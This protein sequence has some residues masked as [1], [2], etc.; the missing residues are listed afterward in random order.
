MIRVIRGWV[1]SRYE[2]EPRSFEHSIVEGHRISAYPLGRTGI[3]ADDV[4]SLVNVNISE[5]W[6]T[7]L[8]ISRKSGELFLVAV[9]GNR[10]VDMKKV[11]MIVKDK[12]KLAIPDE[13]EEITG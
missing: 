6:K 7:I 5:I 13:I 1:W 10:R 3:H 11:G 8:L 12:L 9:P 4:A 2:H